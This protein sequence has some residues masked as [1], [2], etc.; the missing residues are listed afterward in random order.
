[1]TMVNITINGSPIQAAEGSTVLKAAQ[2]AGIDIPTLCHHP[3][4]ADIGACRMCLVEIA[5]QPALQPACT[6]PVAEGLEIQTE[7]PKVEE[8]RKFVL[9]MLFSERNHYCM[10]CEMS[11]DCELQRLAYRYGLD[12][13][14]YQ[15]PNPKLPVDGTRKYFIMDHNRCILCRRCIRACGDVA[16]NHTLGLKSRGIKTMIC[17]D[18]DAPFGESTCVSCGTC[19]QVCPTGALVDRKSAYMGRDCDVEK[20]SSTC[21]FCSVGCRT[22]IVTRTGHVLRVEGDWEGHNGGVLCQAGRFDPVY[23]TRE[24]IGS[25]MIRKNGILESVSWDEALDAIAEQARAA[26]GRRIKAWTTGK[27]SSET[28]QTFVQVFQE[29]IRAGVG[30]LE[31]TLAWTGLPGDGS[32]ADL[33][34]TDCIMLICAHPLDDHQVVGYRIKRARYRGS[35]LILISHDGDPMAKVAT[36]KLSGTSLDEAIKYCQAA[37]SPVVVYGAGLSQTQALKLAA[38]SGKAKFIPLLPAT[39]S[40][41]AGALGLQYDLNVTDIDLVYL[42][43]E[44]TDYIEDKVKTVRKAKCMVTHATHHNALTDVADIVLPASLWHERQGTF[45]NLEGKAVSITRAVQ[46]PSW[47]MPE[48]EVLTQLA[49]RMVS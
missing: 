5:K 21:T 9:E 28:M 29:K 27:V 17:A 43:L 30:V 15:S 44:D 32:L 23:D 4:L 37:I 18:M 48:A 16:A 26:G 31:P 3:A 11:G 13:W 2:A 1:M 45:R 33:D 6:Y 39:N 20:T 14:T 19:L 25:P 38:L 46:P 42:L 40:F 22:K 41:E 49:A 35:S 8:M 34:T 10:F 12:H 36:Q 7:T 24:R 47:L